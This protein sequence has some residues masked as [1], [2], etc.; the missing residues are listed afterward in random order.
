MNN[1]A[2][3]MEKLSEQPNQLPDLSVAENA[4]EKEEPI[5]KDDKGTYRW[6]YELPMKNSF[7]LLAEVWRL[8]ALSVLFVAG[9]CSLI[10][11]LSGHK[12]AD[13]LFTLE[14]TALVFLILILLSIPAYYTVVKANN[15]L[16]TVL[17]E[18]NDKGIDHIQ[19]KTEKA[20]AL[21]LLTIF[22]GQKTRKPTTT[23]AGMLSAAGGSLYSDFKTVK[24]IKAEPAKNLITLKGGLLRNQVYADGEAFDFVLKYITDRCPK[25]KVSRYS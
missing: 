18:M 11:Y 9:F 19:I 20:R 3:V 23:A 13:A 14:M 21:E 1:N 10:S 4:Y 2:P 15:G 24:R 7:F 6:I 22:I 12:L 8:I 25:A 16:Y 5:R 17:F